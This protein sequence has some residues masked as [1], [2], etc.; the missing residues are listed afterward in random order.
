MGRPAHLRSRLNPSCLTSGPSLEKSKDR[1]SPSR[2]SG[3]GNCRFL[4]GPGRTG[5]VSQR[6]PG[7]CSGGAA[8]GREPRGGRA[9]SSSTCRP[10]N[11]SRSQSPAGAQAAVEREARDDVPVLTALGPSFRIDTDVLGDGSRE[12]RDMARRHGPQGKRRSRAVPRRAEVARAPGRRGR[13]HAR[14]RPGSSA[15]RAGSTRVAAGLGW[16]PRFYLHESPALSALIVNRGWTGRDERS[17]RAERRAGPSARPASRRRRGHTAERRSAWPRSR[18]S[19]RLRRLGT[20]SRARAPHRHLQQQL[21]GRD[22]AETG[23][24][25][26]GQRRLLRS[27]DRRRAR[28]CSV[29]RVSRWPAS[30]WST[31]PACR[32]STADPERP[33]HAPAHDVAG[34]RSAAPTSSPLCRSRARRAHSSTES[35]S[36]RPRRRSAR[37]PAP[38]RNSSSLSGFVGRRYG[39][40][41]LENGSP[42]HTLNA[43]QSQDRFAQVLAR[44]SISSS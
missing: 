36:R 39:F 15:T 18:R 6:V 33:G 8:R 12:R 22:A 37:R 3:S 14:Q 26:A 9:R 29:L 27:R 20:R 11:A 5:G 17:D 31:A 4:A 25:R 43:E 2:R 13:D 10:A 7:C 40:S 30:G 23:R 44:A 35:A 1:A 41:I 21:H 16:K 19:A 38:T 28:A 32:C 34:Q 42:V 24:R